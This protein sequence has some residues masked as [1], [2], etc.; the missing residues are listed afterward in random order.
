MEWPRVEPA[1]PWCEA[2]FKSPKETFFLIRNW[3]FCFSARLYGARLD[4]SLEWNT[5]ALY[6]ITAAQLPFLFVYRS[7]VRI[8]FVLPELRHSIC[9]QRW[10]TSCSIVF[11]VWRYHRYLNIC[12][13]SLGRHFFRSI[14]T[15]STSTFHCCW[16]ILRV[17]QHNSSSSILVK[18]I[19]FNALYRTPITRCCRVFRAAWYDAW[20]CIVTVVTAVLF[21]L[22]EIQIW[23]EGNQFT[24]YKSLSFLNIYLADTF[25]YQYRSDEL[26]KR[27]SLFDILYH[28]WSNKT[29]TS[30]PLT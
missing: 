10:N 7:C 30:T 22:R 29:S 8:S 23:S 2:G 28:T 14:E 12:T 11:V 18:N 19:E 1:P 25:S 9:N 6:H 3:L 17:T 5:A 21:I 27:V 24:N 15:S 20:T 13:K 4:V 16:F 26:T